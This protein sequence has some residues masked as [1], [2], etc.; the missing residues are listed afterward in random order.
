MPFTQA[1]IVV[2]GTLSLAVGVGH[3]FFGR[4]FGWEGELGRLK[5]GNRTVLYTIHVALYLVLMTFGLISIAH[6]AELARPHGLGATLALALAGIWAWRAVWQ[7]VYFAPLARASRRWR[8][9]QP[10][11]VAVAFVLAAAYATPAVA[12]L[13]AGS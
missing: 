1:T 12:A 13:V 10:A 7:V 4:L 8:R 11:L 2:A 9:V 3:T 6:S 5:P